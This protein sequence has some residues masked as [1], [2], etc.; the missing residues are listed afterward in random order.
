MTQ[1][2]Y[3]DNVYIEGSRDITQLAVEEHVIQDDPLQVWK[4]DSANETLAEVKGKGTFQIGDDLDLDTPEALI[5]VPRADTP[6]TKPTRGFHSLGR[7]A[8]ALSEVL[9][10]SV[11]ELEALRTGV[12]SAVLSA[13]QARIT[14]NNAADSSSAGELRA[15]DVEAGLAQGQV[16]S[17]TGLRAAIS[18]VGGAVTTA[19]G[20]QVDDVTA[21]TSNYALYSGQGIVHT[22]DD[23]ELKVLDTAP[24]A[25]ASGFARM[26][27]KS[28]SFPPRLY[29]EDENGVEQDFVRGESINLLPNGSFEVWEKGIT[30][31]P[32]GWTLT[33]SGATVE[34]EATL[35][36]HGSYSAKLTRTN[37]DCHLS[38]DLYEETG[39]TYVR[40]RQFTVGAWLYATAG[41]RARLRV[42][43]G[44]TISYSSYHPGDATWQFLTVTVTLGASASVFQ[45]G[46]AVDSGNTAAYVDGMTVVESPV[47]VN[48]RPS[49]VPFNDFPA[50]A[51]LWMDK[52]N[53]LS[54]GALSIE[55]DTSQRYGLIVGQVTQDNGDSFSHTFWLRA[56]SYTFSVLGVAGWRYGKLDWY[57][58]NVLVV[59]GQNWYRSA[60][61]YNHVKTATVTVSGD[62]YHVLKGVV[63]GKDAASSDYWYYFTK[64]WFKPTTD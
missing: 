7:I 61:Q 50:R 19:Y 36:K 31:A 37:N 21:G 32:S 33:G 14:Y 44:T 60:Y 46:L 1:I 18:K 35:V 6:G 49:L 48:S 29:I 39:K 2:T 25:S 38:R 20:V 43:D 40:S 12:I 64:L 57:L 62:G 63:N 54:G 28:G 42:Y 27:P 58:D 16:K 34:Q 51:V 22:G 24:A 8:G 30:S 59:S 26:Y 3:T 45:V 5:T 53:V 13:L 56:G 15:A 9:S 4:S 23:L 52:A 55:L 47:L 17:L 11:H 41:T 10:W